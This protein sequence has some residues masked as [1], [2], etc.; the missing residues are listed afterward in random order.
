MAGGHT[1]A[2]NKENKWK[3]TLE[4]DSI[5][6]ICGSADETEFHAVIACTK[7]R[8]LRSEIRA[9]WDIPEEIQFRDSG[10]DWLQNLLA[11]C[12]SEMRTKVLLLLW[13]CW[14]LRNNCVFNDGKETIAHS[15][16][17]LEQYAAE[18]G[19]ATLCLQTSDS[20]KMALGKSSSGSKDSSHHYASDMIQRNY[21]ESS[22]TTLCRWIP[23]Q[24]GW[25]KIN[26]D[27]SFVPGTGESSAGSIARD[28]RGFPFF[29]QTQVMGYSNCVEV[30]EAHAVL[31]GVKSF[32]SLFRGPVIVETDCAALATELMSDKV[33]RAEAFP[34]I[35]DIKENL[36]VF[37]AYRVNWIKR[38][39]NK[40]AH[41]LAAHARLNGDHFWL[42]RVPEVISTDVVNEYRQFS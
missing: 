13:R 33:I 10:K 14:Y 21:M 3:R 20:G 29:S 15:V 41:K 8:A 5:C 11:Q 17:F 2:C 37:A 32:A 39:Q 35:W 16:A 12:N 25:T 27:A 34:F 28:H 23:P 36:K 1:D 38:D 18:T 9:V 7:S 42:A 26:C 24:E 19:E 4:T 22:S 30:A 6:K 40:I 31:I